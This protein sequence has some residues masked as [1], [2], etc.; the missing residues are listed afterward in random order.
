MSKWLWIK[1]SGK[2]SV[3]S[4]HFCDGN[5]MRW[6][7]RLVAVVSA[8]TSVCKASWENPILLKE[9]AKVV[10]EDAKCL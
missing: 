8:F 9:N 3:H 2:C 10:R 6:E 5:D 4:Q 7:E 1:A